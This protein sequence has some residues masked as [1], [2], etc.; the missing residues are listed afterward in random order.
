[1]KDPSLQNEFDHAAEQ[2]R[3]TS[4]LEGLKADY[5]AL[6]RDPKGMA[7]FQ[8]EL[9]LWDFTINDGLDKL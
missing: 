5:A 3:R 9:A 1:M 6:Q 4:Y 8:Q 2:R 7:E